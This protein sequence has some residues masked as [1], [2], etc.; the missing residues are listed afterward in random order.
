MLLLAGISLQGWD[1]APFPH[2]LL[3]MEISAVTQMSALGVGVVKPSRLW[4]AALLGRVRG[5][6][7]ET[8]PEGAG[9]CGAQRVLE[10]LYLPVPGGRPLGEDSLLCSVPCSH[11]FHLEGVVSCELWNHQHRRVGRV[12]EGG[13]LGNSGLGIQMASGLSCTRKSWG[14]LRSR[15]PH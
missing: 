1:G 11:S 9:R 15:R 5:F 14:R 12:S 8:W 13:S 10:T 6:G 3:W 2:R 4:E 7:A